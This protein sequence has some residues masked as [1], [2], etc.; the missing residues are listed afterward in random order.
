MP[1]RTGT[2]F[3][4]H[5]VRTDGPEAEGATASLEEDVTRAIPVV[6]IGGTPPRVGDLLVALAVGGRWVAEAGGPPPSEGCSPCPI[7]SRD[8]TVSWIGG[9]DDGGSTP[10]VYRAPNQW[11]SACANQLLYSLSCPG[12]SVQFTATYFLSGGCPGG[13]AYSCSSRGDAPP[14]LLLDSYSCRPFFL[15]YTVS[16]SGCP[17]LAENG[18]T[19][20]A[21]SE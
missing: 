10:L 12:G 4:V 5:P 16:E 8:L 2:V 18:I 15:R 19:A 14:A 20:F 9:P 13:Q 6:V 21:I 3:L 11:S 7:P 1:D 17:A